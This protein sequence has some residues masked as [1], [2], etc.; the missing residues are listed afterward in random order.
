MN[1]IAVI[2]VSIKDKSFTSKFPI[3][4]QIQEYQIADEAYRLGLLFADTQIIATY[5]HK[6]SASEF[7]KFISD[8]DYTYEIKEV[9]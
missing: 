2:N 5:G 4:E 1:R 7:A 8:L 9:S 3:D 6:I